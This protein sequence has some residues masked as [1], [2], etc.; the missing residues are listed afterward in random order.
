MGGGGGGGGG[1]GVVAVAVTFLVPPDWIQGWSRLIPFQLGN[2]NWAFTF[3]A[4]CMIGFY[5]YFDLSLSRNTK[6]YLGAFTFYF[7]S[8]AVL[9]TT[10]FVGPE[11]LQLRGT[12]TTVAF[13]MFSAS[14]ALLFSKIGES[15]ED[16]EAGDPMSPQRTRESLEAMNQALLR[17]V[18]DNT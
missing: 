3:V 14:G 10:I 9:N 12:A 6:V 2:V 8:T 13:L 11:L 1:V 16:Y 15:I 7:F 17:V 4:V 5:V 18:W